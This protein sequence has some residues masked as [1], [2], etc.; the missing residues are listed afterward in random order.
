MMRDQRVIDEE[1]EN[2]AEAYKEVFEGIGKYE[3]PP[4]EIQGKEGVRPVVQPPRRIQLHYQEPLRE[5]LD[6]MQRL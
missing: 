2:V 1:M 4:V 5:L 3:G 6:L